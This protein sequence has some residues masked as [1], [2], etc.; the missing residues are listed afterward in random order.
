MILAVLAALPDSRAQADVQSLERLAIDIWPDY[1]QASV[2]VLLTG[3]LAQDTPLPA[4]VTLP[5]PDTAKLNAFAR[6]DNRDGI[7]KDDLL[8]SPGDG[9]VSFL[10]PDLMFRMEYYFPYRVREKSRSFDFIWLAEIAVEKLQLKVQQPQAAIDLRTVPGTIKI[11]AGADEL[12]YYT[13]PQRPVPAGQR[14]SVRVEYTMTEAKLSAANLLQNNSKPPAPAAS[15]PANGAAVIT[16]PG[17]MIGAGAV[18]TF[19][20]L[21]WLLMSWR[22]SSNTPLRNPSPKE[23]MSPRHVITSGRPGVK[24]S[25]KGK[26]C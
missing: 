16:W 2:L 4:R 18:M 23:P 19:L 6:I 9:K 22:G 11:A 17:I 20:A 26:K 3:T 1:D 21:V 25:R 8:S 15:S 12:V 13:F 5:L 10:T 14:Y 7:M 24:L